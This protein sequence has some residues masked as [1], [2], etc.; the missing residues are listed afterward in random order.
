MFTAMLRRLL[1]PFSPQ[2]LN[3]GIKTN[4]QHVHFP[5]FKAPMMQA[6]SFKGTVILL[7]NI[8]SQSLL[9]LH[10]YS[11]KLQSDF[12]TISD[13]TVLVTGGATGLGK[14]MAAMLSNL[15][16]KVCIASRN[17]EALQKASSEI[18]DLSNNEVFYYTMDIRDHE[19]VISRYAA[20]IY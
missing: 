14:G 7:V 2:L 3:K 18:A 12:S 6:D 10:S 19:R 13:Q 1:K 15:G 4:P 20:K 9:S 8:L 17:E 5:A 16:A 11:I